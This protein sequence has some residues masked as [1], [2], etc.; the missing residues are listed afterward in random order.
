MVLVKTHCP[1]TTRKKLVIAMA[2]IDATRAIV[3]VRVDQEIVREK[4]VFIAI[5]WRLR[6][7]VIILTIEDRKTNVKRCESVAMTTRE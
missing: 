2:L 6:G 4:Y 1:Y 3:F 7:S 5:L